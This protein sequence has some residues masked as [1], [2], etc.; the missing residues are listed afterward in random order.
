M[1][2]K[3][4]IRKTTEK[5]GAINTSLRFR[6]LD[7]PNE[8]IAHIIEQVNS[9]KALCRLARTC[10]RLQYLAEPVLYRSILLR[11]GMKTVHVCNALHSRPERWIGVNFLDVP[12]DDDYAQHFEAIQHIVLK[13]KNL[14]TLMIESP[15]CNGGNFEADLQWLVMTN[16]LLQPFQVAIG[17]SDATMLS[18]R[19][20]QR[21]EKREYLVAAWCAL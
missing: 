12:C 14:K 21:L 2:L 19:P 6:L 9:P 11:D 20:L 7:L 13:S 15:Q 4:L 1:R 10:S 16:H 3:L 8:L 17:Q 18:D 5:L